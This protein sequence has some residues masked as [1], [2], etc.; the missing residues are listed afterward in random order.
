MRWLGE[1]PL[2][3]FLLA[4]V[5]VAVLLKVGFWTLR[6]LGTPTE[7]PDKRGENATADVESFDVRY[8]CVVCAAEVRLTRVSEDDDTFEAPRHCREDMALVVEAEDPRRSGR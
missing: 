5:M 1:N 7:D 8:R 6:M 4:A 3:L 2:I